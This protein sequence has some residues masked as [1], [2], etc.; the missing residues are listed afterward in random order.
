MKIKWAGLSLICVLLASCPDSGKSP[1]ALELEATSQENE[2]TRQSIEAID[3]DDYVL[4]SDTSEKVSNWKEFLELTTQISYLK[5]ADLS[6]FSGDKQT[7]ASLM[8]DL[9]NNMPEVLNTNPINSRITVVETK[10]LKLHNNLTLDN[11]GVK[12]KIQSIKEVLVAISNLNIQ[13]NKK[14][15]FDS[16]DVERPQ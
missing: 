16:N 12:V 14:L 1:D 9:K 10:I 4:S 7:I 8:S 11:I 3:Y 5:N 6:Y 13:M 2:I 15:E